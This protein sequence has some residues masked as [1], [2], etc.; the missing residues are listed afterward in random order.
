MRQWVTV[1]ELENTE[2]TE[3]QTGKVVQ[4]WQ[5]EAEGRIAREVSD[6]ASR[7]DGRTT[8]HKQ[9]EEGM[10]PAAMPNNRADG[11]P[12]KGVNPGLQGHQ[13]RRTMQRRF[14]AR[15]VTLMV[16]GTVVRELA[17]KLPEI[18]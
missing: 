4:P 18:N 11:S 15:L 14:A 1:N 8:W 12:W 17:G 5:P 13:G 6:L 9:G 16:L 7:G 2:Y 10:Q 3:G